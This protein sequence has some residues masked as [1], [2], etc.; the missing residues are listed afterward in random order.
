M[1]PMRRMEEIKSTLHGAE[2]EAAAGRAAMR[3]L[4]RSVTVDE[5]LAAV[6]EDEFP[7]ALLAAA[8]RCRGE[9]ESA[10]L[11][12]A[13]LG[14]R[15]CRQVLAWRASEQLDPAELTSRVFEGRKACTGESRCGAAG[16][17][18]VAAAWRLLAHLSGAELRALVRARP[19]L[20]AACR[21]VCDG[22]PGRSVSPALVG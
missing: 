6:A 5:V 11:T 4:E 8:W 7:G 2:E 22:G 15:R 18:G 19:A 1:H 13:A 9:S 14:P 3:L 20:T 17:T 12:L 21:R 16:E 10:W